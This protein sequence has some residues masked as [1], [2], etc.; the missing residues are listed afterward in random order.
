M[1]DSSPITHGGGKGAIMLACDQWIEVVVSE[2]NTE[3]MSQSCWGSRRL[4]WF[5]VWK[6]G[7]GAVL[8]SIMVAKDPPKTISTD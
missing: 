5:I 3:R 6:Y 4:M 1:I 7:S 8:R 2:F